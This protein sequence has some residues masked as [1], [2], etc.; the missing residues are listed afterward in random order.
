M[1][2]KPS[3]RLIKH[4]IRSYARLAENM[5]VRDILRQNIPAIMREKSFINDLDESSKKW[6]RNL[7]SLLNEKN[8]IPTAQVSVSQQVP[9]QSSHLKGMNNPNPMIP[10]MMM[11][12]MQFGT[13]SANPQP[14]FMIQ[15][16][17]NEYN[18]QMYPGDNYMNNPNSRSMYGMSQA[19]MGNGNYPGGMGP[20]Y[21]NYQG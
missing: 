16:S 20:Y 7:Q 12:P 18:Y 9:Q 6:M 11:P 15:P 5:V 14:N 4:I 8:Q 10:Q 2:N 13:V 3:N 17:P 1:N 19:P 21:P